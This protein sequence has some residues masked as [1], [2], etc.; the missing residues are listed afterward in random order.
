MTGGAEPLQ[1]ALAAEH[2]AVYVYALL[3]GRTSRS[4]APDLYAA[5]RTAYETHRARR[6]RLQSL[7]A[8]R[9]AEPV[10]PQPAYATPRRIGS[11]RGLRHA[12]LVIEQGCAETYAYVVAETT[13]TERRWGIGAL[14]DAAV[15]SLSF[16]AA[17]SALPGVAD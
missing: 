5:L 10:G 4:D 2:A 14:A 6:D 8:D 13:G 3:G 12:A 16:G 7:I 11:A 9:G 1:T 17:P 15:R